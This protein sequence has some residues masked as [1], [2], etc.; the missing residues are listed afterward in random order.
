MISSVWCYMFAQIFLMYLLSRCCPFEKD[1]QIIESTLS[2]PLWHFSSVNILRCLF[3]IC[4]VLVQWALLQAP[5]QA[6]AVVRM[7][8]MQ[9]PHRQQDP[10]RVAVTHPL[11]LHQDKRRLTVRHPACLHPDPRRVV[12]TRYVLC[13]IT[14]TG[15]SIDQDW[16]SSF[17][18]TS[19]LACAPKLSTLSLQSMHSLSPSALLSGMT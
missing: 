8:L 19:S 6:S 7:V 18:R 17:Q 1:Q 3:I 2:L 15:L 11:R 16:A 10:R 9:P 5:V 13:A 14:P 4:R 12:I